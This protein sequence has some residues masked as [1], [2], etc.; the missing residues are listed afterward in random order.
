VLQVNERYRDERRGEEKQENGLGAQAE[1]NEESD[2]QQP[3]DHLHQRIPER[4]RGATLPAPAQEHDVADDRDVVVESDFGSTLRAVGRRVGN[5]FLEGNAINAN[6]E[7]APQ[8][9][10]KHKCEYDT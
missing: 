4:N 10:A 2:T 1:L 6:V 8:R 3:D 9:Q 5:R 7:E